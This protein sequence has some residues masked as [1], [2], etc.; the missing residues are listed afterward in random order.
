MQRAAA[1]SHEQSDVAELV[2]RAQQGDVGA[3]E[4]LYRTHAAAVYGVC[5]RMLGDEQRSRELVQDVFV[6]AWERLPTFRGE[7]ALATWLHRLSVNMV[8]GRLRTSKREESRRGEASDDLL[9]RSPELDTDARLDLESAL[10]TLAPGARQVFVL[11][12]MY[13]YSH[14]EIASLTGIAAATARVQLWRAR[15][16]LMRILER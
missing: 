6:R 16:A 9:G 2:R 15:R 7:S 3:F 13:G 1:G 14:D 8:L 10:S 4:A 5:Q 11:H 12:D